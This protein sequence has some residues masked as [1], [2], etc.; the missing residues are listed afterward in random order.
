M[1]SPSIKLDLKP[2]GLDLSQVFSGPIGSR[3]AVGLA[4][5]WVSPRRGSRPAVGLALQWVSPRHGSP[6]SPWVLFFVGGLICSGPVSLGLICR[7]FVGW[8]VV[9]VVEVDFLC[10]WWVEVDGGFVESAGLV[11]GFSSGFLWVSVGV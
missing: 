4:S 3:L 10:C 9:V 8:V 2:V 1:V 7:G 5:S 11:M 6:P